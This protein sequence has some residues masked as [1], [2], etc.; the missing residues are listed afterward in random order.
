[1]G[2]K[3]FLGAV[4]MAALLLPACGG[5]GDTSLV[6]TPSTLNA[7]E[8]EL[9]GTYS[10]QEFFYIQPGEGGFA[11]DDFEEYTGI[12]VLEPDGRA[13]LQ[14]DLCRDAQEERIGCN[15]D[16]AWSADAGWIYLESADGSAP[17]AQATWS[18]GT[19]GRLT[20]EFRA[21]INRP[22]CEQILVDD[23]YELYTW[24]RAD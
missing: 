20:T 8:Q 17:P 9:V 1:M 23:G 6:G 2:T 13:C 19:M 5:G 22:D 7:F 3:W 12:L 15:R 24:Q 16:Y 18:Q 14:L 21:P 4:V 10:L 11:S